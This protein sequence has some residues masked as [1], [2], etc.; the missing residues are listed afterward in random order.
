MIYCEEIGVFD[1]AEIHDL[2]KD[3]GYIFHYYFDKR[4]KMRYTVE[5][6]WDKDIN[7]WIEEDTLILLETYGKIYS[8]LNDIDLVTNNDLKVDVFT[9]LSMSR[10]WRDAY[11]YA[12][13]NLI[14]WMREF[15]LFLNNF[16]TYL[17]RREE[18]I[19][20]V[21]EKKLNRAATSHFELKEKIERYDNLAATKE[22]IK[23]E[24]NGRLR[25]RGERL[26]LDRILGELEI[27][28]KVGKLDKLRRGQAIVKSFTDLVKSI[29]SSMDLAKPK[30]R[31]DHNFDYYKKEFL[32]RIPWLRERLSSSAFEKVG[33]IIRKQQVEKIDRVHRLIDETF[34]RIC[35]LLNAE[36]TDPER[37]KL[38]NEEFLRTAMEAFQWAQELNFSETTVLIGDLTDYSNLTD[39]LGGAYISRDLINVD[40]IVDSTIGKYKESVLKKT[41]SEGDKWVAFFSSCEDAVA[42]AVQILQKIEEEINRP[43]P[44]REYPLRM[45]KMGI[46]KTPIIYRYKQNEISNG[47]NIASRLGS[48]V[49]HLGMTCGIVVSSDVKKKVENIEYLK[50]HFESY[51]VPSGSIKNIEEQEVF[52]VDWENVPLPTF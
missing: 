30:Q 33:E 37:E 4:S 17:L 13:R 21:Y 42:C 52:N 44:E 11:K 1:P 34:E 40:E 2:C 48:V 28:P 27:P 22:K 45:M 36:I 3:Y 46:E 6:G 49:K 47:I 24:I 20:N 10:N 16:S 29:L 50:G 51:V 25:T 41:L 8:L 12:Y 35:R 43:H 26:L 14:I 15:S 39:Q 18:K 7:S 5:D 9:T 19:R 38:I 32:K 23:S 31:S